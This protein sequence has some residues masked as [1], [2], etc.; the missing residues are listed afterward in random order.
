METGNFPISEYKQNLVLN[1][2]WSSLTCFANIIMGRKNLSKNTIRN[3]FNELVDK[4]DYV[5][6][7]KRQL[8]KF[9]Y[10]LT[11]EHWHSGEQRKT[12]VGSI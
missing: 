9:L 3:S 6:S 7:E 8:S 5:N 11:K 10:S 4:D 1:P 2:Y 12:S